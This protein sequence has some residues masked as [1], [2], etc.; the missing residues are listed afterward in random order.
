MQ[1]LVGQTIVSVEIDPSHCYLRFKTENRD[2]LIYETEGD[3]CSSSWIE[4]VENADQLVGA[5][6]EGVQ[7]VDMSHKNEDNS[8]KYE[9]LQVYGVKIL[10]KDRPTF[11]LEYRNSSNGY[12][13]GYITGPLEPKYLPKKGL[14][15]NPLTEDF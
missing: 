13:G 5:K 3:C 14:V 15:F 1:E 11:F 8:D 12:Y 10:L 7:N 6:V 9:C 2:I 4:H